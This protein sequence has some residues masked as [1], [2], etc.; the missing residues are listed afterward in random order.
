MNAKRE[1]CVFG[2]G[3]LMLRIEPKLSKRFVSSGAVR[4]GERPPMYIV[5]GELSGVCI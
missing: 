1:V 5:R 2:K 4:S 3:R